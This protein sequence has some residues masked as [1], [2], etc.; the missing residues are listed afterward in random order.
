MKKGKGTVKKPPVTW[1]AIWHFIWHDDSLGSW[2][3]NI[4]LAF[5]LIKFFV[6]PGLG[7]V[8]GTSLP[9]VAVIS[10]SMHHDA[11]FDSWW[12]EACG[13]GQPCAPR[14]GSWYEE[15]GITREQFK[16]YPLHNGFSKGDVIL[17]K[18]VT[19]ESI[20]VGDIIVFASAKPYPIIHRVFSITDQGKY[21]TK[22]DNNE[23]PI[24]AADINELAV[25]FT[26]IQG[27]AIGKI[28]Y[29]GYIKLLAVDLFRAIGVL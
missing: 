6:Y 12:G 17:L 21:Q 23:Y 11:D 1:R 28:P 20:V 25:D 8:F 5:I 2:I 4:L 18:G 10:D 15:Q 14:A 3:V 24:V 7:L 9:L 22:G 29:I 26:Q 27:K 19:N 16:E 13:E